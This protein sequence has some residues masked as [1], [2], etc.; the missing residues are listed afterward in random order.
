MRTYDDSFSGQKIY[1]GKVR[2]ADPAYAHRDA[3][4]LDIPQHLERSEYQRPWLSRQLT[5]TYADG[6]FRASYTSVV[7]A[8]SS[9][10]R[11]A[12]LRACSSSAR[13]PAGSLGPFS[14]EGNTRRV[15]LRL[16][17]TIAQSAYWEAMSVGVGSGKLHDIT[18]FAR[19][20]RTP[21]RAM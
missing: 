19:V 10:S 1:P 16:V 17:D 2:F 18:R 12:S 4:E 9:D 7:T 6:M 21:L 5:G 15:S 20:S 3:L 8:R 13:T 14:S 11:M